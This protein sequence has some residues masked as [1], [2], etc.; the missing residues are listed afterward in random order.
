MNDFAI[1]ANIV[2]PVR[3][4]VH[5][6]TVTVSGGRIRAVAETKGPAATFLL[7][8]LVD[9]HVHVE[10]S[11]LVPS[12]FA[13]LAVRHGTVAAVCDP[14]EIANVLG[15]AGVRFMIENSRAVPF[16]F[17]F[18]AS[19][20]VPATPFE[21]AGARIGPDEVR[22]M[23]TWPEIGFLAEMMNFPGAIAGDPEVMAKIAAAHALG[24]PVDGHAPGLI[25]PEL[26][27]YI[28]HG[29]RTD[30]EC[31]SHAEAREKI[32][33]GMKILLR[34]GSAAKNLD[35]LLPLLDEFP[36]HCMFATDDIKPDDLARDHIRLLVSR[37][38][39]SGI[40]FMKVLRAATLN[41]AHHYGL[42]IGL[43]QPGDPADF[44]EVDDLVNLRVLRTFINGQLTASDGET[45][46][47]PETGDSPNRFEAMAISPADLRVPD[48]GR[49]VRLIQTHDG[50]LLTGAAQARCRVEDGCLVSDRE[51]DILKIVVLNRYQRKPPALGFVRG[52]GLRR[53][54]IASSVAHD[55][56]NVIAVGVGDADLVRAINLVVR[57]KGGMA[58]AADDISEILPLPVAGLMTRADGL[59]TAARYARLDR[60]AKSLGSALTAPFMTLSFMALPVIPELKLTD[61]GLF[62]LSS[63][64]HV[65]LYLE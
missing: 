62:E 55:S 58:V 46:I 41:P 39:G 12:E 6:G 17:A 21:S 4:A 7:P 5:P 37:A 14:H 10:S 47:P 44:I 20:C 42:K 43:L 33:L 40:D 30:H 3:G 23:L 29:I 60:L 61:R 16:K 34:E 22:E 49:P 27:R 11:L 65:D 52:F 35:M 45:V 2:D 48:R 25:G 8:G 51:G 54:A 59:E 36:E 28:D 50:Q 24:K 57:E 26:A 18:G 9:A 1:T 19:S 56:H 13:R 32:G 31:L 63:F 64:K 53:G 15:P 38:A